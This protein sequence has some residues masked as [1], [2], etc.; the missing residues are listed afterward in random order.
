MVLFVEA[1]HV[2]SVGPLQLYFFAFGYLGVNVYLICPVA[3]EPARTSMK[4]FATFL[5]GTRS[6]PLHFIRDYL[7]GRCASGVHTSMPYAA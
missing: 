4:T 6:I 3:R 1:C 5:N 7:S 2:F